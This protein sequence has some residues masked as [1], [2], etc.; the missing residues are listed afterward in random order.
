[1]DYGASTT[2]YFPVHCWL[3]SMLRTICVEFR[4]CSEVQ[5]CSSVFSLTQQQLDPVLGILEFESGKETIT[6]VVKDSV[7]FLT[8]IYMCFFVN[9]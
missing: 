3:G 7:T 5:R 2:R 4:G 9:N 1:M 8:Y 6:K